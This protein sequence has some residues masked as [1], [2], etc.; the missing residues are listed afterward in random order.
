MAIPSWADSGASITE[1][2]LTKKIFLAN[3]R[4]TLFD[5]YAI[6]LSGAQGKHKGDTFYYNYWPRVQ[7]DTTSISEKKMTPETNVTP[8]K[9]YMTIDEYGRGFPWT[10]K[11]ADLSQIPIES[12]IG[13]VLRQHS[14]ETLDNIAGAQFILA[15]LKLVPTGSDAAPT[16][17]AETTLA[18][19]ATRNVQAGDFIKIRE[20]M[21]WDY[22]IPPFPDGNYVS[23]LNLHGLKGL[24][25]SALWQNIQLYIRTAEKS[26]GLINAYIGDIFGFH[27]FGTNNKQIL[28]NKTGTG[29]EN[30]M[31]PC[32]G[33]CF[34]PDFVLKATAIPFRVVQKIPTDYGRDRGVAWFYTGGYSIR[35]ATAIEYH[36]NGVHITSNS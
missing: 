7:G 36:M 6:P 13:Q 23:I 35:I 3:R 18:T 28:P 12:G 34:G 21:D 24:A 27:I 5:R 33:V 8:E 22:A 9:L 20:H 17:T 10:G 15:P 14:A 2:I 11:F 16:I 29:T 32:Q 31:P 25:E 30:S 26:S 1:P 4:T 19:D